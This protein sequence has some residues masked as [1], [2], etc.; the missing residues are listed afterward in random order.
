MGSGAT[1]L[2]NL[3]GKTHGNRQALG[4]PDV[5]PFWSNGLVYYEV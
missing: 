4:I 5:F 2:L 1:S 3:S